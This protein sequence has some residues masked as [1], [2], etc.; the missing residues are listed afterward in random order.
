MISENFVSKI[1]HNY[2]CKKIDGKGC[3]HTS[4]LLLSFSF[5]YE[6]FKP[7]NFR[8]EKF[9]VINHGKLKK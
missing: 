1:I 7:L 5:S 8:L 9:Q 6:Y 2:F 3:F 4:S